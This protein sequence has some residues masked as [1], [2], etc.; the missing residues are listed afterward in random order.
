[1]NAFGFT[2]QTKISAFHHR[3]I[4]IMAT[5][6]ASWSILSR[7]FAPLVGV[8]IGLSFFYPSSP[9]RLPPMHC[10][11]A[12]SN[13]SPYDSAPDSAWAVPPDELVEKQ[14]QIAPGRHHDSRSHSNSRFLTVTM[15]RQIS[16]GGVLGLAT[17][18]GLRVFSSIG[19]GAGGRVGG[20]G[21]RIPVFINPFPCTCIKIDITKT[22][23]DLSNLRL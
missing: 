12:P 21:G 22:A 18:L 23:R 16:L 15:M 8:G 6:T 13:R 1:M 11:F 3:V 10:Q 5:T 2:D 17:G 20:S 9:F 19:L 7:P 4:Q 14:S